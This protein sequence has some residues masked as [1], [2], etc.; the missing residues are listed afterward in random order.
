MANSTCLIEVLLQKMSV[1][2]QDDVESLPADIA[3]DH[4]KRALGK[5][6]SFVALT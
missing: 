3:I 2:E 5:Q 6:L 1:G 4:L